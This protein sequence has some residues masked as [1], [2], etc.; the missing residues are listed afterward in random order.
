[1]PDNRPYPSME[2]NDVLVAYNTGRENGYRAGLASGKKQGYE[3]GFKE[4]FRKGQ[5]EAKAQALRNLRVKLA[6]V[7]N[8]QKYRERRPWSR[9][10]KQ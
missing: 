5:E 4:G 7:R 3:D 8:E 9:R 10:N 2:A 1:M 6:E